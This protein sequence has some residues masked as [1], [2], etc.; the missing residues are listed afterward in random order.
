MLSVAGTIDITHDV[1]VPGYAEAQ[2]SFRVFELPPPT[3]DFADALPS[4]SLTRRKYPLWIGTPRTQRADI[5]VA[6]PAGWKVAY[7]PPPL[8]GSADG[9]RY[10]AT[11][12][13]AGQTVTCH[14]EVTLDQL[15]LAPEQ[16][17]G[18]RDAL[19]QLRAYERRIVL[20]TKT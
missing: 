4:A 15:D 19:T 12:S 2:G 6:V 11:C 20:L 16:Y 9:I 7:V 13:A 10:E 18:L 3:L 5:S 14:T 1:K 8:E 17:A